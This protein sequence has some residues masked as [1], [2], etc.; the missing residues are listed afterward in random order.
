M[1]RMN[2]ANRVLA[3]MG[4]FALD[5]DGLCVSEVAIVEFAEPHPRAPFRPWASRRCDGT[6]AS[7]PPFIA[8]HSLEMKPQIASDTKPV[9]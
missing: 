7:G 4:E 6:A 3:L 2:D 8:D 9:S 1:R 5:R